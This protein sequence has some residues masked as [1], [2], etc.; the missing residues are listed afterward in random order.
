MLTCMIMCVVDLSS[1]DDGHLVTEKVL[2]YVSGARFGGFFGGVSM[3]MV[4]HL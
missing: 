2:G 1:V 4:E 3:I